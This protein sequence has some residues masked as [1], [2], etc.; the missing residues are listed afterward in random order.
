LE[1]ENKSIGFE[2]V[3]NNKKLLIVGKDNR[4][5]I[6]ENYDLIYVKGLEILRLRLKSPLEEDSSIDDFKHK[7]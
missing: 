3:K 4:D 1:I 2:I 7:V 5:P 6:L